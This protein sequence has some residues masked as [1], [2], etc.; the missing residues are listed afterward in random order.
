[1]LCDFG[2]VT[3]VGEVWTSGS[4][5][6][7]PPA[8]CRL[9]EAQALADAARDDAGEEPSDAECF[10]AT[11]EGDLFGLGMSAFQAA[12]SEVMDRLEGPAEERWEL[13]GDPEFEYVD[14]DLLT[15]DETALM[16]KLTAVF[17][18]CLSCTATPED[19]DIV[20]NLP[21]QLGD[22]KSLVEI[23]TAFQKKQVSLT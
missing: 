8:L 11:R 16:T 12:T 21:Q 1:V 14:K 7:M 13:L 23:L 3:K 22:P 4:H 9:Q 18:K 5:A 10:P 2:A 17:R 20:I 19:M 6:Y 15:E